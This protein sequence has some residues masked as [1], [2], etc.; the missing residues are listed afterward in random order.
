MPAKTANPVT[1]VAIK[2]RGSR[3]DRV[4]AVEKRESTDCVSAGALGEPGGELAGES[5]G[6]LTWDPFSAR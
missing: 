4:R 5:S 1:S 3:T 6:L 2:P